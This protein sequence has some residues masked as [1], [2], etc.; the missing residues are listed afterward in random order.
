MINPSPFNINL[1]SFCFRELRTASWEALAG[2]KFSQEIG[3]DKVDK[4]LV[5][6]FDILNL[7]PEQGIKEGDSV[8]YN[9][10]LKGKLNI[11]LHTLHTCMQL[12]T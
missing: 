9:K 1:S 10:T 12:D 8:L 4:S 2:R 3:V 6:N 11:I 7:V 5:A